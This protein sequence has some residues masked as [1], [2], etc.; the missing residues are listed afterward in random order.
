MCPTYPLRRKIITSENCDATF[1]SNVG[2]KIHQLQSKA[3]CYTC[4]LCMPVNCD[5]LISC[6]ENAHNLW[7][8]TREGEDLY[9]WM[10]FSGM[11][12]EGGFDCSDCQENVS[13]EPWVIA[14]ASVLL[15]F[16]A[17]LVAIAKHFITC[18][19]KQIYISI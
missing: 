8:Q 2:L 6:A 17:S 4:K 10:T 12:T 14:V 15:S 5:I 7:C 19:N 9:W 13:C 18:F 3:F 1:A 11:G 16:L